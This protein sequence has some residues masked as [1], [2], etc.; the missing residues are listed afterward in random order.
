MEP[1]N[2]RGMDPRQEIKRSISRGR[3]I[4][5]TDN[6]LQ[7]EEVCSEEAL[8]I[9][10]LA[11][12]A[13]TVCDMCLG[14]CKS[15]IDQQLPVICSLCRHVAYCSATCE[16]QARQKWHRLECAA[17]Q[18]L[19][20]MPWDAADPLHSQRLTQCRFMV[21]LGY[22]LLSRPDVRPRVLAQSGDFMTLPVE[23]QRLAREVQ[24]IVLRCTGDALWAEMGAT[25]THLAALDANNSFGIYYS[26]QEWASA[27]AAKPRKMQRD[28]RLFAFGQLPLCALFNHSCAPNLSKEW[29][30][31]VFRLKALHT[32]PA[33]VEL[34]HSYVTPGLNA[35]HRRDELRH[36]HVFDCNCIRCR[37]V[38][39]DLDFT[40]VFVCSAG[41]CGGLMCIVS[42]PEARMEAEVD[43]SEFLL[44]CQW[45][46]G[47]RIVDI[48]Q[49]R[50]VEENQPRWSTDS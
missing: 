22:V 34:V 3:C 10:I 50:R 12:R 46:G 2:C 38:N 27:T 28:D 13:L 20:S 7:G 25:I 49:V 42:E 26:K 32:V 45:C 14:F 16:E 43:E 17:L 18:T 47:M 33:G 19:Q 36:N 15:N 37:D 35:S 8:C 23:Q 44:S 30:G 31:R 48:E 1:V 4:V 11:H 29:A 39:V 5:S 40:E 24:N 21:R 9:S 6:I 41:D